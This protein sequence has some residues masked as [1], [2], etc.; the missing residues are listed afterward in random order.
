MIVSADAC[1]D[2]SRD[3]PDLVAAG[4]CECTGASCDW[5]TFVINTCPRS[6]NICGKGARFWWGKD[7][8][9]ERPWWKSSEEDGS[10]KP[11]WKSSEESSS[12][13]S[14]SESESGEGSSENG[15]SSEGNG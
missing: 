3:C 9:E 13:S 12:S 2:R 8:S 6:C 4:G 14:S 7:S 10:H 11:W 1:M 5:E 15:N